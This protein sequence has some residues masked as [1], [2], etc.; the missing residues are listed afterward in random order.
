MTTHRSFS[1]NSALILL[2]LSAFLT[3]CADDKPNY[4]APDHICDTPI[5]PAALRALL[6]SGE[7]LEAAPVP[8]VATTC[9]VRV[10]S[11]FYIDITGYAVVG[12]LDPVE[13][14]RTLQLENTIE[15]NWG[16]GIPAVLA[17]DGAVF[18]LPCG[19]GDG[20]DAVLVQIH[21]Y[22]DHVPED[23]RRERITDFTRSYVTGLAEQLDCDARPTSPSPTR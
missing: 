10:D 9:E 22:G 5:D 7:K 2:A 21:L 8:G 19:A 4:T 12:A 18:S 1:R 14:A 11:R 15:E 13:H 23:E 20:T 6:P 16:P 3:A 17:D